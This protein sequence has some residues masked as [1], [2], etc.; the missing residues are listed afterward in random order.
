MSDQSKQ[1]TIAEGT[2]IDGSIRSEGQ[3]NL[4]GVLKGKLDAPAL[5][6]TPTG[7][8]QGKIKVGELRSSGEVSGEI[9]AETAELGGRVADQT[10]IRAKNLQ[11]KL[12]KEEGGVKVS[13]GNCELQVGEKPAQAGSKKHG[14]QEQNAR[15]QQQQKKVAEPVAKLV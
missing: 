6:V 13:F 5:D 14:R 4:S 3:I 12:S 1:T 8:V 7:K 2:V 11:V 15:D 10:V 9:L